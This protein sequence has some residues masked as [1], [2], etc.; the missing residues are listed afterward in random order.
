LGRWGRADDFEAFIAFDNHYSPGLSPV[1][2]PFV[3][4]NAALFAKV[5]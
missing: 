5:Q 3:F 2:K 4:C 1:P